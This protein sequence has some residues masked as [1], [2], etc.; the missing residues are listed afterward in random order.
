MIRQED[1]LVLGCAA[2]EYLRQ[3]SVIWTSSLS[4][5]NRVVAS[6]QFPLPVL[7]YLMWT[8][9]WL[10][11]ELKQIDRV[12][13]KIVVESG[14]RHP[15]NSK[16][17]L[18]MPRCKGGR[19]LRSVEMEY[20]ATKIMGAA[21]IHGNEDPALGMVPEFEEQAAR[22]GRRSNFKE[23]AKC[24]EELGLELDLEQRKGLRRRVENHY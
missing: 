4:D 8:Q 18:Y 6:N 16:A 21:R 17:L 2:K 7:G 13:H 10:V 14:G 19:G 22:M 1:K 3:L 24:A 15:C 12:V 11:M 20:K 23:A 5:Y 9:Q